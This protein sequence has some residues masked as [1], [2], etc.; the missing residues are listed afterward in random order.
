M[1]FLLVTYEL[2]LKNEHPRH[3]DIQHYLSGF[4]PM[5]Q[6]TESSVGITTAKSVTQVYLDLKTF[7]TDQD[8]LLV[9]PLGDSW[10][11][12]VSS[13]QESHYNTLQALTAALGEKLNQIVTQ[14]VVRPIGD[15]L[16]ELADAKAAKKA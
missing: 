10:S 2:K 13:Q 5:T 12:Q 16:K 9:L 7:L 4:A 15:V 1:A 11:G 8:T 14:V 3:K 6:L